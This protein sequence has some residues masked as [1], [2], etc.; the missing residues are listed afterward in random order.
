MGNFQCHHNKR[1][2]ILGYYPIRAKGQIL[3]LLC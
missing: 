3:R 2:I 1:P